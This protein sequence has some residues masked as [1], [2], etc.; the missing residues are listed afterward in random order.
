MKSE[1][2]I[3]AKQSIGTKI[4]AAKE[5]VKELLLQGT[6]EAIVTLCDKLRSKEWEILFENDAELYILQFMGV[7]AQEE[8]EKGI[9]PTVFSGRTYHQT[10][11]LFR[12]TVLYLRRLEFGLPEELQRELLDHIDRE[13]M[14]LIAILGIIYSETYFYQ[15]RHLV[16][17]FFKLLQG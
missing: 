17:S 1:R 13:E 7:I 15:K 8:M 2:K 3:N 12:R 4:E 16:D 11:V 9:E 6:K 5:E 14:S 10:L